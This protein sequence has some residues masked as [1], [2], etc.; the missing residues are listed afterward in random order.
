MV[1]ML[2]EYLQENNENAEVI[3]CVTGDHTTPVEYGDHS[4]EPVP[5]AFG[6][7]SQ[8]YADIMEGK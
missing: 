4:F 8:V 5:L 3:L 6:K 1:M 7:L 2:G